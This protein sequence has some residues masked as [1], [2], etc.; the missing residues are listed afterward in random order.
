[1]AK[2]K[3]SKAWKW[4]PRG[5]GHIVGNT[6]ELVISSSTGQSV[7]LGRKF[8]FRDNLIDNKDDLEVDP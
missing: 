4:L 3:D 7:A 5:T 1:M 2:K 8:P 6:E